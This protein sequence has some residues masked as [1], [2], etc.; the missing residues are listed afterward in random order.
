M[1]SQAGIVECTRWASVTDELVVITYLADILI[2]VAVPKHSTAA[3]QRIQLVAQALS[4]LQLVS[5][6]L[7][8]WQREE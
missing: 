1:L 3:C 8:L 5:A 2:W 4:L 6:E 7:L